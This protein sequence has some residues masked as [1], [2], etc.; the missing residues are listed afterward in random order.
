LRLG[1]VVLVGCSGSGSGADHSTG[2]ASMGTTALPSNGSCV[3]F[4][5]AAGAPELD[6]GF[7]DAGHASRTV[8]NPLTNEGCTGTDI[9]G[10][11]NSG[12]YWVCLPT[13]GFLIVNTDDDCGQIC[14]SSDTCYTAVCAAD[15][16]CVPDVTTTNGTG[17]VCLKL[18]CTD[19]DCG[20]VKDESCSPVSGDDGIAVPVGNVGICQPD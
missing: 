13:A 3:P 18:C 20:G 14:N 12:E 15:N 17:N 8:C 10:V 11:D 4:T 6:A 9:C 16:I 1:V 7:D 2:D 19:D 5:A